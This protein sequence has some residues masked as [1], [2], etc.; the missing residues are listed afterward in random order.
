M[1]NCPTGADSCCKYQK[2]AATMGLADFK[3]KDPLPQDVLEAIK[4]IYEDLTKEDLLERCVGG[5]HQK[6]YLAAT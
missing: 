6:S 3:H 5:L 1:K 2:A 4:P